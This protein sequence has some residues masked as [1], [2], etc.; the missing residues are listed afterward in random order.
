LEPDPTLPAG[1]RRRHLGETGSTNADALAAARSGDVGRLWISAD[2][3]VSGRG[4]HG[5]VWVSEPGNLY[6]S[7]LLIDPA[8]AAQIS[9]LP[10]VAALALHSALSGLPGMAR[11]EL[12][13]KWP[14]DLIAD[15]SKISGILL[16]SENLENGSIAVAC[17]FGV[18]IAHHPEPAL[19]TATDLAALGIKASPQAV[20]TRLADSLDAVLRAWNHGRGFAAIRHEWLSHAK[21][22]GE[23]TRVNLAGSAIEGIF[24]DIDMDGC[25]LL[26]HRDGTIQK[27]S[28]GDV[29]FPQSIG[30]SR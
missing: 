14:N 9:T 23:P 8:S 11:H 24:E 16:E 26:R 17:G 5:R 18:N 10:F 4:R 1:W 6:A 21:G 20:F 7:A 22:R 29:F 3:Q 19:Y 15:G 2:R 12:K 25:L 27:I 28:A 30:A 13:L